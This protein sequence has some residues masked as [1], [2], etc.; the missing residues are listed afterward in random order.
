MRRVTSSALQ[1]NVLSW[2][3]V[4]LNL[5]LWQLSARFFLAFIGVSTLALS[6]RF[7]STAD[8]SF[9]SY[10]AYIKL[11]F[12]WFLGLGA[13]VAFSVQPQTVQAE[14]LH[15]FSLYINAAVLG[16]VAMMSL[17]QTDGTQ[18]YNLVTYAD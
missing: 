18:R 1:L 5:A 2:S 8:L 10:S 11:L 4:A 15:P 13:V 6:Y 9:A 16:N 17:V 12:L 14:Y 3:C 7:V